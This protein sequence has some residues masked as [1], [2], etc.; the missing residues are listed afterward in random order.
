MERVAT[1]Y[2]TDFVTG[3]VSVLEDAPNDL[4]TQPR[5]FESQNFCN[6]LTS[7]NGPFRAFATSRKP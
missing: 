7:P 1:C 6:N 4:L 3:E 2:K 5:V